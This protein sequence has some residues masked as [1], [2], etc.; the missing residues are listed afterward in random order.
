MTSDLGTFWG[1]SAG[2]GSPGWLTLEGLE[3]LQR[4][5]VVAFPQNRA[6][7]PGLAYQIVRAYLRPEQ[8][9]LAL[10]L[11]FEQD[12]IKLEAAW[13]LAADQ[14]HHYLLQ[15]QSV[16]F[17]SEGDVS[18]YSTFTYLAHA[19]QHLDSRI[20]IQV[21]PGVCSPLAAVAALQ[22]PLAIGAEKLA[23]LPAMYSLQDLDQATAWADVVVLLKVAPVFHDVWRWLQQRG[24]L[25]QACLVEW[26]GHPQQQLFTNLSELEDHHPPYFSLLILR[27]VKLE[28]KTPFHRFRTTDHV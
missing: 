17:V 12:L 4:S 19:L 22:C 11:P 27:L 5:E 14:I 16:V 3:R 10:N 25:D 23:V 9:L 24:W 1:L 8:T 7:E 2:A 6:G 20:P 18:L 28:D 21:V 13:R 26:V 15:G